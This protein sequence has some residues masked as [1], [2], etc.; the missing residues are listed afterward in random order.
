VT[1][2]YWLPKHP[3]SAAALK[4]IK[5][6][7]K[8]P[9]ERLRDLRALV[10]YDLDFLQTLTADKRLNEIRLALGNDLVGLSPFKLAILSSVTVD[11]LLAALRVAALRRGVLLDCYVGSYNQYRQELMDPSSAL[12]SFKPDA[13]LLALEGSEAGLSLPAYA[14]AE[15]VSTAVEARI[16]EWSRYWDIIQKQLN[17]VV[18]HQTLALPTLSLFGH[19]DTLIPGTPHHMTSELNHALIQRARKNA[20][21][22]FDW[23]SIASRIGKK[24]I[25]DPIL[26][27]HA[28]QTISPAYGPL[29]GDS[30]SRILA[31]LR[32]RSAKCLVLD[33]DNTLWGGVIGDDGVAGIEIGQGTGRGE[34][35]LAFQ[36]YVFQLKQRGILLAICSKNDEANALK[37]FQ[38]HPDMLLRREDFTTLIANW[39]HKAANL[40][41]IAKTLNLGLDSLVF[42]D[43]NPAER[44]LVRQFLPQVW[45]PEVPED[46]AYYATCLSDGGYFEATAFTAD[47]LKRNEQYQANNRRAELQNDKHDLESFL[48]GL[49]MEMDVAPFD[50]V[51]LSRIAQLINKSNQF[52]LTTHRYTE[53]QVRQMLEDPSYLTLQVRLKDNCGDNGMISVIIARKDSADSQTLSVD[54]WLMSCR[55]LGRQVEQ[56]VLNHLVDQARRRGYQKIRGE[57]I[58]TGK[59]QLVREHYKGLGFEPLANRPGALEGATSWHLTIATFKPLKNHI[60]SEY[61]G[62]VTV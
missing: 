47:D 52:N 51:G 13:V 16:E 12:F 31:A 44:K 53:S 50:E 37:P 54:T 49:Q 32:G 46:P 43:D 40:E 8:A 60:H 39:D 5:Q 2:L 36:Q 41:K 30:L 55:V 57:F 29:F 3:D 9:H 56:E 21:F 20:V 11:H 4:E 6:T 1:S 62:G 45:V 10:Q 61:R 58:P 28:K 48:R 22:L 25:G 33:L 38:E 34:A 7:Q 23:E 18:L 42:F 19:F 27:H 14:S 15:D 24:A 17:A 26:W 35:F 59:N